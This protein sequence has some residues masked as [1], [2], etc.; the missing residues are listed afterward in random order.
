MAK[1]E[2]FLFFFHFGFKSLQK[3]AKNTK[4]IL[5]TNLFVDF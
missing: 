4:L 2:V 1:V 5:I 3:Q